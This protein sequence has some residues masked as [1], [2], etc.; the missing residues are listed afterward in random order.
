MLAADE[1]SVDPKIWT[2]RHL[3][4]IR[5]AASYP[6]VERIFVHPGIKQALCREAGGP[7]NRPWLAKVRPMWGHN[8]HFHVRISC[9]KGSEGCEPQKAVTGDD[10]CGKELEDWFA[11][12]K[13]PPKPEGP[14]KPPMTVDQLPAACKLVLEA[15]A[16]TEAVAKGR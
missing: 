5:R 16:A 12:L 8:Y 6:E 3:A 13:A 10:G 1:L 2:P 11:L 4:L 14:P 9:P 15:P 7:S